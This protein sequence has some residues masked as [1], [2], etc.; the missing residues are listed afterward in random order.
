MWIWRTA[1][2]SDATLTGIQVNDSARA[3]AELCSR[4]V[5]K[6]RV[7]EPL[8]FFVPRLGMTPLKVLT[9]VR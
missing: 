3:V 5:D 2:S 4:A 6:P 1:D 9:R 7:Q 8:D